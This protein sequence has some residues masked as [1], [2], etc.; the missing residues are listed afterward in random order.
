[1]FHI[2]QELLSVSLLRRLLG[3]G[4]VEYASSFILVI[5]FILHPVILLIILVF[6]INVFQ[7][8][9]FILH[10]IIL[11]IILQLCFFN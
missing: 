8:R 1:M 11:L 6:A 3:A 5:P 10:P 9:P 4:W 2:C 7:L